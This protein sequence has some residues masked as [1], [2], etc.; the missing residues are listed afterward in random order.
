MKLEEE[1]RC[2]V[3]AY[4]GLEEMDEYDLKVYAL[5]EIEEY[6]I[7][8]TKEYKIDNFDYRKEA[9]YIKDNI[10]IKRKLQSSL[11]I[12]NRIDAPIELILLIK[13]KIKKLKEN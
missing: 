2:L 7:S 10:D 13:N 4:Y 3:E 8:F 1:Y 6:I 12:L 11:I 9:I 5:K